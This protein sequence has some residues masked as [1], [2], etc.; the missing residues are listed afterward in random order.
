MLMFPHGCDYRGLGDSLLFGV[1]QCRTKGGYD[2]IL[3]LRSFVILPITDRSRRFAYILI[4]TS[5]TDGW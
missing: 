3:D 5:D 4:T 1:I 2:K